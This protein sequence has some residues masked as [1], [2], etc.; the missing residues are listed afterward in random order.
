MVM[1]FLSE[2]PAINLFIIGDIEN[3]GFDEDFQELWGCF[4]DSE[5]IG[6][7][8][9]YNHNYIPYYKDARFD[10]TSFI[11]IIDRDS[12]PNRIISGKR[13][14]ILRFKGLLKNAFEKELYFC[15]LNTSDALEGY[16]HG[17]KTATVEDALR[18]KELLTHIKEFRSE[19]SLH[20]MRRKIE[21][22]AGRIF[23]IE[24]QE[25][26]ISVSQTTAENSMSA[27]IVGVATHMDYRGRGLMSS[28][29]SNLC[30]VLLNEGKTLCLF[31]DNP[32]A[33]SVYMRLGFQPIDHWM[34]IME[35]KA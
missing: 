35:N 24:D 23:Y 13:S 10:I 6:V 27:M 25:K 11:E 30:R 26:V 21:T 2:E 19:Q 9:R 31:Y 18:I 22:K 33:G 28:C 8:L 17:V 14:I 34:M 7:L 16:N 12:D 20:D 3:Y 1:N 32:K 15:Q 29:L 4:E 5:L